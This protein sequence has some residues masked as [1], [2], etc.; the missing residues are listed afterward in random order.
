MFPCL[1]ETSIPEILKH[2]PLK[3]LVGDVIINNDV[4]NYV[5]II[6]LLV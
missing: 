5:I 3:Y 4:G 6:K 1:G 2:V